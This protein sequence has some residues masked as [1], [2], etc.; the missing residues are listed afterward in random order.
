GLESIL[1]VF[2]KGDFWRFRCGIGRPGHVASGVSD[3]VLETFDHQD[4][5]KIRELLKRTSKAIQMGLEEGL[6]RAMN[7]YNTK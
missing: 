4:K 3:Y 5:G 6:D 2:P 7:K 1:E